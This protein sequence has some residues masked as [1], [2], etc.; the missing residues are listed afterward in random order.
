[1]FRSIGEQSGESVP[2]KTPLGFR[3]SL[4]DRPCACTVTAHVSVHQKRRTMTDLVGHYT[5]AYAYIHT[6]FT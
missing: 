4:L 5:Y 2:K 6:K 3:P 1:M